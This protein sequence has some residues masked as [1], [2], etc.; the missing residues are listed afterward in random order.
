VSE[1]DPA[2]VVAA[3]RAAHERLI[4][5]AATIDDATARQPSRLPGWTVGHVLTHLARNADGHARRLSGALRGEDLPRYAGGS[6]ERARGIEEGAGRPARALI[7]DVTGSAHRLEA[8][9]ARSIEAGWPNPDFL[10]GDKFPIT[11]SPMRRLRE[12]EVHHVDLGLGYEPADW[13][14]LYLGWELGH[15]LNR[16][17]RRLSAPD[18]RS[19]LAWLT[20]RGDLPKDLELGPWM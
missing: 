5:T 9:W 11:A 1:L 14:D 13:P 20:G 8:V 10:G 19:L 6:A 2:A 12:V 18:A 17:P 7:A 15:A 4:A 16:L 3:C